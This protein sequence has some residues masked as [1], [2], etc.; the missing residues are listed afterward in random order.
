M[1]L[2]MGTKDASGLIASIYDAAMD[3]DAWPFFL[4]VLAERMHSDAALFRVSDVNSDQALQGFS[5]GHDEGYL[6]AYKEHYI[7]IDPYRPVLKRAAAG[8]FYPGQVG[9]SYEDLVKT[10]IYNDFLIK[11]KCHYTMGGYAMRDQNLAYQV[12]VHRSKHVG[13]FSQDEIIFFNS[14][15]PHLQR[16]FKINQQ[17]M[18]LETHKDVVEQSLNQLSSGIFFLDEQGFVIHL[19][20]KAEEI[21]AHQEHIRLVEGKLKG[22]SSRENGLLQQMLSNAIVPQVKDGIPDS[23]AMCLHGISDDIQPLPVYVMPLSIKNPE[24]LHFLRKQAFAV[25]FV[26]TS[27]YSCHPKEDVLRMLYGLTDAEARL[28]AG[29]AMGHSLNEIC[30][31]YRISIHTARSQIKTIFDKTG[32]SRQAEL[33]TLILN[34]PAAL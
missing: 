18:K 2:V 26:G 22:C 27:S 25:L 19:N 13:D 33:V 10:E 34:S 5:H 3:T 17:M 11:N 9:V 15:I 23:G 14:L 1:S 4:N 21:L 28:A 30:D 8:K 12:A 32:T 6:A 29:L 20:K 16:A 7:S 24:R 31:F